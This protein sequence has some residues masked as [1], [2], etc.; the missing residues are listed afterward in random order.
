MASCVCKGSKVGVGFDCKAWEFLISLV[1]ATM[2]EQPAKIKRHT[3]AMR[4]KFVDEK[5]K[6]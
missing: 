3:S 1:E 4:A 5:K 2:E 6:D